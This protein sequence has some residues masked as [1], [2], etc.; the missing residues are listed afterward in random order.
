MLLSRTI[1]QPSLV[2]VLTIFISGGRRVGGEGWR[3]LILHEPQPHPPP[4]CK[5][6]IYVTRSLL[7]PCLASGVSKII[8]IPLQL[9]IYT[10]HD[11]W[12]F[13]NYLFKEIGPFK[14]VQ[15]DRIL[16]NHE[17]CNCRSIHIRN[18]NI[19]GLSKVRNV[20]P[21]FIFSLLLP[22]LFILGTES[23]NQC[24]LISQTPKT[25]PLV[26]FLSKRKDKDCLKTLDLIN[27]LKFF[28]HAFKTN[29]TT[30]KQRQTTHTIAPVMLG[31]FSAEKS[32]WDCSKFTARHQRHSAWK[33]HV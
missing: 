19:Y 6:Q 5:R 14:T 7:G 22:C 31:A 28:W 20:S 3:L 18:S 16:K 26:R 30:R 17:Q 2:N 12:N 32:P 15:F 23:N 33:C 27:W 24:H 4:L 25:N 13:S 9:R 11:I 29:Q 10:R 1:Q 21:V 8:R